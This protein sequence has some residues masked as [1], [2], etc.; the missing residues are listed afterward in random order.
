MDMN[1]EYIKQLAYL[2]KGKLWESKKLYPRVINPQIAVLERHTYLSML[3]LSIDKPIELARLLETSFLE[4]EQLLNNRDYR[5]FSIQKKRGGNREIFE[6]CQE[7]KLRQHILNKH[8]QAFYHHIKPECVHGFVINPYRLEKTC[9]IVSNAGAHIGKRHLLNMDLLDFFPSINAARIRALFL[10]VHFGY[11]EALATALALLTTH[12]GKLPI[13]APTS[14]ALSNFICIEMD[15]QLQSFCGEAG[16]V[17]TRYADDLSFSSEHP[18]TADHLSA[19][20]SIISKHGFQTNPRKTRMAGSNRKQL[21]TGLV[22]NHK[23]NINRTYLKRLRAVVHHATQKGVGAAAEQ[24]LGR[25]IYKGIYD[26]SGFVNHIDGQIAFVGQIRGKEDPVYLTLKS[27]FAQ[28]IEGLKND[29]KNMAFQERFFPRP[30]IGWNK[31]IEN[32]GNK[33]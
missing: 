24:Y 18:F 17:Y 1:G 33:V 25:S 11:N 29:F 9:N 20:E 6:P 13:G 19:I 21:V 10:S 7:L 14:P 3:L 12:K 22:V 30:K 31:S 4:L 27:R 2:E 26:L 15:L 32:G 28:A 16:F 8:L 23:V 5:Y